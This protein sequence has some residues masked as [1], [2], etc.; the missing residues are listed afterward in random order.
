MEANKLIILQQL[1]S[2]PV[3]GLPRSI[4]ESIEVD[5]SRMHAGESLT[6]GDLELPKGI[7]SDI[8]ADHL[9]VS[10]KESILQQTLEGEETEAPGAIPVA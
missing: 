1:D 2:L 10:V 6:V 3:K 4:P 7:T 5:V 9:V 8:S